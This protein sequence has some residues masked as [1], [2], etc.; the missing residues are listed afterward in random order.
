MRG[1]SARALKIAVWE[2]HESRP[3]EVR[4]AELDLALHGEAT[5]TLH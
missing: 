1:P 2:A 5:I 3:W 4:V